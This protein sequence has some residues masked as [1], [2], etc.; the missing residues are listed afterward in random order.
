LVVFKEF[1]KIARVDLLY[2]KFQN[3][4]K[5][6]QG[7]NRRLSLSFLGS[8]LLPAFDRKPA[9]LLRFNSSQIHAEDKATA[10]SVDGTD[11][12]VAVQ[13]CLCQSFAQIQ[14]K[15]V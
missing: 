11:G 7:G 13:G 12:K 3:H 4:R 10:L 15:T 5:S 2:F 6:F 14:A 1:G 9:L 8:K